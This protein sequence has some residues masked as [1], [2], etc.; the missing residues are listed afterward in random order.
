VDEARVRTLLRSFGD[1]DSLGYFATR[2]DKSIVWN[3]GDPATAQAGVSYRVIG[4]VSLAS[5]N[6][7]GDPQHWGFAIRA[8]ASQGSRAHGWS[9]ACEGAGEL[10]R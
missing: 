7:V 4:S 8:V 9:L 3:T 1:W 2:R 10:R 5:G 6:P